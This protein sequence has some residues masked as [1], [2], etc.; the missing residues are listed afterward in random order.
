MLIAHAFKPTSYVLS[1]S[2]SGKYFLA[3]INKKDGGSSVGDLCICDRYGI[4]KSNLLKQVELSGEKEWS[5]SER[6]ILFGRSII[7]TKLRNNY[8][9]D[10]FFSY[11]SERFLWS[12]LDD[13]LIYREPLGEGDQYKI[14]SI[15]QTSLVS[16]AI[17]GADVA[18]LIGDSFIDGESL[19][20]REHGEVYTISRT[21]TGHQGICEVLVSPDG[22]R[23]LVQ[24]IYS[25]TNFGQESD[26]DTATT[27]ILGKGKVLVKKITSPHQIG[28][29]FQW[30]DG[31]R[32]LLGI[33]S[34]V[35][36][37]INGMSKDSNLT[38]WDTQSGKIW[39]APFP[40]HR[41]DDCVTVLSMH[42][43]ILE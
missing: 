5:T 2:P 13:R 4:V 23:T 6:N 26:N 42:T 17:S 8:D 32:W 21:K 41:N 28:P 3:G 1:I 10:D 7:D 25:P 34:E 15:Q 27:Y 16:K 11:F 9:F 14:A 39:L 12:K 33:E 20:R 37:D 31:H 22:M 29:Y 38:L 35:Q 36:H 30:L 40:R 18:S 43:P 19:I 24:G